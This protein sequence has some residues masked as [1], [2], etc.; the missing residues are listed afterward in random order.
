MAALKALGITMVLAGHT[1]GINSSVDQYIYSFHMPLFFFISGLLFSPTH[2]RESLGQLVKYNTRRLVVPYLSFSAITYIPWFLFTRHLGA[3]AQL[4][5][6][7]WK[8]II[9]T[10]YGIGINGWLQHNAML[11]FF[12]CLFVLHITW[13]VL[14]YLEPKK[15]VIAVIMLAAVGISITKVLTFRLPWNIEI[16]FIAI[17]FF[18]IGQLISANRDL[19]PRPTKLVAFG[20]ICFGMIQL[21]CIELNGRTDMN[22][23]SIGNPIFFYLGALSGISAL[24]CLVT[25]IPPIKFVT[26]VAD[27]AIVAFPLHRTLYSVFSGVAMLLVDNLQDFKLSPLSSITYTIGALVVSILLMPIIRQWFPSLIGGR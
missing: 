7:P 2:S 17:P 5:I 19:I 6:D 18:S 16:A 22:F 8:P 13:K 10:F 26:L 20:V 4:N 15:Q 14:K 11:W 25:F 9:G 23:L 21:G 27:S 24:G 3:D 12:P 1:L